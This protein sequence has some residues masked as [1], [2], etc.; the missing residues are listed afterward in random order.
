MKTR[1]LNAKVL[2]ELIA[3]SSKSQIAFCRATGITRN[4]MARL[5]RGD[6]QLNTDL[7][8]MATVLKIDPYELIERIFS[9]SDPVQP[10]EP[11]S[12]GSSLAD[13]IDHLVLGEYHCASKIPQRAPF[14]L[15]EQISRNL[16]VEREA[17]KHRKTKE[18]HHKPS[19][20]SKKS[21]NIKKL[22]KWAKN[23]EY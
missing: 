22:L 17:I 1:K 12:T 4:K 11:V 3:K 9:P 18:Y 2:R 16:S 19:V 6:A 5:L 15:E 8:N 10:T 14:C 13:A 20:K 7:I 23:K 21:P